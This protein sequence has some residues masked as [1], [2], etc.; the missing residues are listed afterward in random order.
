MLLAFLAGRPDDTQGRPVARRG[1]CACVAVGEDVVAVA[2]EGLAVEADA[3]VDL[4][5]LLADRDGLFDE[6]LFYRGDP[7]GED[8]GKEALHP[9]D[10]PEEVARRGARLREG[11]A[12]ILEGFA[13]PA[14]GCLG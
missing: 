9:L 3:A 14:R 7:R 12:E 10:G 8:L 13:E 2:D 11:L 6:G 1:Q 5:V 4:D